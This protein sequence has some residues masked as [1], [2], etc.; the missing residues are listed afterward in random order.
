MTVR[1]FMFAYVTSTRRIEKDWLP[2]PR[3]FARG[4]EPNS[5]NDRSKSVDEVVARSFREV[6]TVTT[7]NHSFRPYGN[8]RTSTLY[9]DKIAVN[10]K[11]VAEPAWHAHAPCCC[12]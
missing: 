8:V 11:F 5:V 2:F 10:L 6:V 12:A 9:Q 1:R 4:R 7:K 3:K